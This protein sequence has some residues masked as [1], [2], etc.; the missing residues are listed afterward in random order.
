MDFLPAPDF[1]LVSPL[2][3]VHPL[4][5]ALTLIISHGT[6]NVKN[7]QSLPELTHEIVYESRENENWNCNTCNA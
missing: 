1:G 2:Q 6:G 4:I 3:T 5:Y 7:P